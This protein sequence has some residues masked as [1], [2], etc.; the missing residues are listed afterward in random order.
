MLFTLRGLQTVLILGFIAFCLQPLHAAAADVTLAWDANT[1]PDLEGYVVHYG[2]ASRNYPHRFDVGNQ[3]RHTVNG[4]NEGSI[5]YFAV[6]AYDT[7]GNE[8][9][10]STELVYAVPTIDSDGDG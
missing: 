2:T 7:S 5:Y 10:Y 4:L 9:A 3:N 8:S 1:E 6:T